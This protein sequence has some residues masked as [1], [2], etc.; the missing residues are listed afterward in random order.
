MNTK[1]A[2]NYFNFNTNLF[3]LRDKFQRDLSL[4]HNLYHI[5]HRPSKQDGSF[6]FITQNCQRQSFA[7]TVTSI[8]NTKR[9][10]HQ[11]AFNIKPNPLKQTLLCSK[12]NFKR[13]ESQAIENNN[14]LF[15]LRLNRICSPY[16]KQQLNQSSSKID[17]YK[18]LCRKVKPI[19][20]SLKRNNF[21]L[22]KLPHL[23][24]RHY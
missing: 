12:R 11:C 15:Q 6:S 19:K 13:L 8:S 17:Y 18:R 16:S 10:S 23:Y 21:I 3:N 14:S 4:K 9:S 24:I 22:Y 20:E 1:V 5:H 7:S 2:L